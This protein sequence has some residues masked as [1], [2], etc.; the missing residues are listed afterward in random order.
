MTILPIR[1]VEPVYRPPSEAD[2]LILPL[3]DGCSWN[4]CTFCE[5][6]TA[7]HKRFRPRDEAETLASIRDCGE[8]F[9]QAVKRIFL[10][11]G[12]AMTLSTR[13]LVNVLEAIRRYLPGVRRVS[14][15][16]LPRNLRKN[17]LANFKSSRRLASRSSMWA[18]NPATTRF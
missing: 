8:E 17:R 3:T 15:Y 4:R 12:D 14:S 11:A 6:Y 16:C 2:S 13:R 1:Y 5:M 18:P 7:P 10:A 9:G